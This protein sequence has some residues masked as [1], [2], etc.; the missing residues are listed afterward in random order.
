M[1]KHR[2][3]MTPLES[4]AIEHL[5]R[6]LDV[7]RIARHAHDRMREK[8]VTE[9][10]ILQTL[11]TGQAIEIHNDANELRVL[12]RANVADWSACVV[13][14]LDRQTVVT[15]WRNQVS[16]THKTLRIAEYRW[17][18]NVCQLLGVA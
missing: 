17:T 14:S 6:G 7:Q 12:L 15:V 3:Q 9:A 11:R 1:K 2:Q 4:E 5:V 10:Q 13:F 8:G 18:V 16:D